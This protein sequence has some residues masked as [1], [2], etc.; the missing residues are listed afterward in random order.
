MVFE[1]ERDERMGAVKRDI[2]SGSLEQAGDTV[3]N[4]RLFFH[5]RTVLAKDSS[6]I[7]R[8]LQEFHDSGVGG[9]YLKHTSE[10][11]RNSIGKE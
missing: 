8:L 2:L 3:I 1:V 4:N 9:H 11:V 7:P 10:R 6:L 5:G